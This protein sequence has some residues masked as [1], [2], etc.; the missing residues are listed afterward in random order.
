MLVVYLIVKNGQ[1]DN[2]KTYWNRAGAAFVNRDGS[3]NLKLDMFPQLSLQI[4]EAKQN[5]D[6]ADE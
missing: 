5:S 1:G 2:Q 4:R 6:S 3:I